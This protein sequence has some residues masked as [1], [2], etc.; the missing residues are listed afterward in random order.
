MTI[1]P[2][3]SP[4]KLWRII[5]RS[6][7]DFID[8]NVL[9]L[10]SSLAF[11]TIFSLPGLL[12]IIIWLATIFYGREIIEGTIYN[13]IEGFVGPVAA[14]SI[15]ETM[16]STMISGSSRIAT[17]IGFASLIIG[18]TAVFGE[19]QDSINLIW[20][21]KSKPKKGRGWLR[22]IINRLLSFSII[23]SLGFILLVSLVINGA[24]DLLLNELLQRFPDLTVIVVY[25]V[26][27]VLN[28]FITAFI[29]GIIFKV[30]PDAK[31]EW[32]HVRVG[33]F[34]TAFF[35]MLGKFLISYYL[36]HSQMTT[37]YGTTG[38]IIVVLLWVYFSAMILYFGAAFTRQYAIEMGSNIY[39][40]KY[41]VWVETIEVPSK[42]PLQQTND[43]Q[44]VEEE[45]AKVER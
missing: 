31:I 27:L 5:R 24:M 26:N 44:K 7:S 37:A 22:L 19:I 18:A 25:I 16:R 28:F 9:K 43:A 40:N 45:K 15:Q 35:F 11:S 38:S 21:L 32:R 36:S 23:V 20:K 4:K 30:L 41:A 10:S 2:F 29:F 3:M 33:A 6:F 17:I 8:D 13:Q 14:N 42:K 1:F 34:T 12:I 39:P